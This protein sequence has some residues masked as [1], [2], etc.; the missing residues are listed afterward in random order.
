MSTKEYFLSDAKYL[1]LNLDI[2]YQGMLEEA[3]KLKDR[4]VTHR[5]GDYDHKGWKSLVLHGLS[6]K[7]SDYYKA[8]G[9]KS[10]VDAA[11]NSVWTEAADQCPITMNFLLNKFPSSKFA[12]VRFMLLEAGGHIA[13]HTDSTT[14]ILENTNISLGNPEGCMWEWGDGESLFMEPGGVYVMNIHYPHKIVNNSDQDRY[15]LIIH[16]HDCTDEWKKLVAEACNNQ[17]VTGKYFEH[18]ILI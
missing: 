17:Q 2:D 9:Y 11:N 12:R 5:I 6:E 4:F 13:E 7:H 16:R 18:E 8:Y 14:P 10:A 3:K 1:K 15:H